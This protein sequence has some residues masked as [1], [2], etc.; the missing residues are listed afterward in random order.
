MEIEKPRNECECL[1][2]EKDCFLKGNKALQKD[3]EWLRMDILKVKEDAKNVC[4]IWI[5]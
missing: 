1:R 3:N 5:S 2:R 4:V